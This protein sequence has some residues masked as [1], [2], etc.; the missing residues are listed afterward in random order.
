MFL[1]S[2]EKGIQRNIIWLNSFNSQRTKWR[3]EIQNVLTQI[4]EESSDQDLSAILVMMAHFKDRE[5][6]IF[7][8]AD[9]S[10][11]KDEIEAQ[12]TLPG[13]PRLIM[14]GDPFTFT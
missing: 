9:V 4:K 5:E 2:Y 8:L 3:R 12:L 14:L 7:L 11:T 1:K 6:A 10:A 13:T